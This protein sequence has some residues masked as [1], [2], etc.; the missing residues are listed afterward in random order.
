MSLPE[1]T[2]AAGR[3]GLDA[4][5]ANPARALVALDF[6]GTLAPIVED[7]TQSRLV[8]GAFDAL[9][10]LT[11]A[12]ARVAVI[13]GRPAATVLEL[14]GLADVPGLVVEGQYGA[15]R[16][17]GGSLHVP[18]PPEGVAAVRTGLPAVL[19]GAD[20]GVWVEDKHLSLVVHTRRTPDPDGEL[21]RLTEPVRALAAAH[22]LEAKAGRYVLEIRVPGVDKGGALRRLVEELAPGA[23]LFAG[24]D[25]GDLPGFAALEALRAEGLPGLTVGA[26][27]AEVPEVAER[28]DLVVDGPAGVVALLTEIASAARG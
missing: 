18:E 3:A 8:E 4:L 26:A 27:S 24:D 20:P 15:E 5:V 16:W 28:V 9:S 7:P 2:T 11:A 21:A 14:G 12:G 1:P 19:A 25:L 22:G 23:L 10:G 6:D 13:T 17:S